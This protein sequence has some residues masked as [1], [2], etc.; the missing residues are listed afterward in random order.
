VDVLAG[1]HNIYKAAGNGPKFLVAI[2]SE[3]ASAPPIHLIVNWPK[4]LAEK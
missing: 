4:L 2:K 1:S 3:A